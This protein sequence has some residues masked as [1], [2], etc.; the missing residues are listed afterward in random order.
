MNI[1][2]SIMNETINKSMKLSIKIL[3]LIF[4]K[5]IITAWYLHRTKA[6]N[7]LH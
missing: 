2:D 3:F 7:D 5:I 1:N 6:E 4:F